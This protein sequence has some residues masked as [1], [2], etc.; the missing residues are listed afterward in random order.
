MKFTNEIDLDSLF[1]LKFKYNLPD[2]TKFSK[3]DDACIIIN[4]LSLTRVISIL[5]SQRL[6]TLKLGVIDYNDK[7]RAT[8]DIDVLVAM[9]IN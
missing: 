1:I 7:I 3:L 8:Q 5:P 2:L 6:K 4:D 9:M